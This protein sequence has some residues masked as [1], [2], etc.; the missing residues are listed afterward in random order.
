VPN[1]SRAALRSF[2]LRETRL[3]EIPDLPGIR[4]R[5]APDAMVV[6][7]RA[8]ALLGQS[9]PALPYWAFPWSGG[10]AVARYVADRPDL[11]AGR[12]VLDLAA[13]SGLCGI[14][15]A[16]SGAAAVTAADVDPLSEAAVVVNAHANDVEIAFVRRDLLDTDPPDDVD[17]IFAG[18][19]CY[20]ETMARRMLTWLEA[21]ARTGIDVLLG[22]PGRAYLPNGLDQVATYT[23]RTT[24]EIEESTIKQSRV[25]LLA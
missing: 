19:V 22:D 14:V 12:R 18:D 20:E 23:V 6:A 8:A 5:V 11:V 10:L 21:A 25:Y 13:G 3:V 1:P 15:A 24:R 17:V 9:D 4:L 7:G 2:V 16:R